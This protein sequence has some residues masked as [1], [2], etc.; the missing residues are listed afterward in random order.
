MVLLGSLIAASWL[1][2][3]QTSL[4]SPPFRAGMCGWLQVQG[5]D[6]AMQHMSPF[7][8]RPQ[9]I[10]TLHA[11]A[12][13]DQHVIDPFNASLHSSLLAGLEPP[14]E[15]V[16]LLQYSTR[17][18][19]S[20]TL[21]CSTLHALSHNSCSGGVHQNELQAFCV[22]ATS[23]ELLIC[24]NL[25]RVRTIYCLWLDQIAAGPLLTPQDTQAVGRLI[26]AHRAGAAEIM[27]QDNISQVSIPCHPTW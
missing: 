6:A 5:L 15:Q 14:L 13:V 22:L 9:S 1:D 8:Q 11:M 17:R 7:R 16:P 21:R 23:T 19:L 12:A 10:Q 20:G 18:C 24:N 27:A 4:K 2:A 3:Q 26:H 25:R